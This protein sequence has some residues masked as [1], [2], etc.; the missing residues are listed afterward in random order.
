M[1]IEYQRSILTDDVRNKAFQ[2]ALSRVITKGR[3]TVL[4]IGSGTGFLS[5]LAARLGAKDV[6]M[7]EHNEELARLSDRLMRKNRIKNCTLFQCSSFDLFELPPVDVVVSETLG[8]FAYE[9]NILE[10]MRDAQ[11][12]LRPGGVMLPSSLEQWI[13]PVCSERF[14][15]ELCTWDE[16]GFDLDFSPAK[17]MSFNNLYVR[18]FGQ[19]DLVAEFKRWDSVDLNSRYDSLRRGE[20]HWIIK[21]QATWYGFASWW[22]AALDQKLALATG[23]LDPITHWEQLYMPLEAPIEVMPGDDVYLNIL[24]DSRD[25]NGV[26]LRWQVSHMRAG[27]N[28]SR[29]T[30]DLRKGGT[31]VADE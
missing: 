13:A 15:N 22:K 1:W 4:D 9:E 8:N 30:M 31:A 24:S 6:F 10:I 19:A 18:R 29:Q 5:F 7:V 21:D 17:A 20:S 23:P 12:F 26:T 25:G 28:L 16:I 2:N 11:R 27:A 3:T 14:Y